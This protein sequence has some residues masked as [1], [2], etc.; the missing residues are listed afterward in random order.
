MK[1]KKCPSCNVT[2][3]FSEFY[4][5]SRRKHLDGIRSSC[6]VCENYAYKLY[7]QGPARKNLLKNQ[8]NY[9]LT[10]NYGLDATQRKTKFLEQKGKCAICNDILIPGRGT[11][12]DHDHSCC[13]GKVT[14]GK[15]IRGLLCHLCN[16]MLSKAKDN[17]NRLQGGILYL[18]KYAKTRGI[19][20]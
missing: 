9:R 17:P 8:S 5:C 20:D 14:C 7:S 1:S 6:K 2:K 3:S 12:I 11:Q 18:E 10:H 13:S 19:S 16:S 15:C 4:K